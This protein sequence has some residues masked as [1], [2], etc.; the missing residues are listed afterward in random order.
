M[1][2]KLLNLKP[3][4]LDIILSFITIRNLRAS[5]QDKKPSRTARSEVRRPLDIKILLAHLPVNLQLVRLVCG[6]HIST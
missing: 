3:Y 4:T 1:I 2:L 5:A 6:L